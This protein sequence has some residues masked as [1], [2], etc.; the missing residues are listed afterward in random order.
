LRLLDPGRKY[1]VA[2]IDAQLPEIDGM[3][4]ARLFNKLLPEQEL[5]LILLQGLGQRLPE[6]VGA[7]G[8]NKPLKPAL[9]IDALAKIFTE[10]AAEAVPDIPTL[11]ATLDTAKLRLMLAED[12]LVNQK[13]AINLLKNLG[14]QADVVVNGLEVLAAVAR[15]PYDIILLDMQMPE[16]DGLEA[17]RRLVA[18]ELSPAVRPWIIALTANAMVGDRELCLSAG[19]DDYLTKPIKKA[20]LVAA[21]DHGRVM[22]AK[23]RSLPA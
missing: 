5:P 8:V 18:S 19:M 16:M 9:L 2:L 11:A 17:A 13:V 3:P 12:N 14:Y 23:R 1:D 6:G 20:E 4:L 15:Q 22:L 21:I 7:I 10:S